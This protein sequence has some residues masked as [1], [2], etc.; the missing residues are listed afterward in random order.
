MNVRWMLDQ[1]DFRILSDI[2]LL[3]RKTKKIVEMTKW[4][5]FVGVVSR[6][7]LRFLDGRE[8]WEREEE[9]GRRVGHKI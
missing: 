3:G 5:A 4:F 9:L 7:P 2:I 6:L 1:L 8:E